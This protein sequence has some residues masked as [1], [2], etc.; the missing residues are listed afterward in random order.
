MVRRRRAREMIK[1]ARE[2]LES[3]IVDEGSSL[4]HEDVEDTIMEDM[5]R[6][7]YPRGPRNDAD[8]T[9]DIQMEHDDTYI[10]SQTPLYDG[11]SFSIL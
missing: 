1:R 8:D 4:P 6:T 5:V 3:Q 2:M 11:S 9:N 10:A 7:F